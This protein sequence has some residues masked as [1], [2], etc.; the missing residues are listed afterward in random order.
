MADEVE[1]DESNVFLNAHRMGLALSYRRIMRCDLKEFVTLSD[2]QSAARIILHRF[3]ICKRKGR[4]QARYLDS[5]MDSVI[6][7]GFKQQSF[8]VKHMLRACLF[9]FL[10]VFEIFN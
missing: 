3:G 2:I 10:Q 5:V 7:G 8:G 6:Q 4:D 9:E 1:D